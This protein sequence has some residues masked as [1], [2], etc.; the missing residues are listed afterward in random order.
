MEQNLNDTVNFDFLTPS[1][2]PTIKLIT[3]AL[4]LPLLLLPIENPIARILSSHRLTLDQFTKPCTIPKW[5]IKWKALIL[6]SQQ[7]LIT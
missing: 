4:P 3:K 1:L 6:P 2:E 7:P 5:A